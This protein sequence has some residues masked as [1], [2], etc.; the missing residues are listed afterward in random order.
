MP[1]IGLRIAKDR[2]YP[3]M[4]FQVSR[5]AEHA[6]E[7][8]SG[9]QENRQGNRPTLPRGQWASPDMARIPLNGQNGQETDDD[10]PERYD[11]ESFHFR[12][13]RDEL[14]K[15]SR[16]VLFRFFF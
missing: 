5:E 10:A 8:A 4:G 7:I 3:G 9:E 13:W 6:V 11:L 2:N 12:D 14:S 1:R 16:C 15:S